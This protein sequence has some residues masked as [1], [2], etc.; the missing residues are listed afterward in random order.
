M[1]KLK[2]LLWERWGSSGFPA[3]WDGLRHGGGKGS[4]RYWEYLW[5]L[6]QLAGDE[7]SVLDVGA[8][9]TQ[10]L[11]RLF[12]EAFQRVEAVDPE[13]PHDGPLDHRMELGTWIAADPAALERF[14]CVTCVSVVEHLREP[15]DFLADLDRFRRAK[16]VLTLEFGHEPPAF[17]FQWTPRTLYQGLGRFRS[18]YLVRMEACP[19]WAD[20]SGNGRW[21]PFGMVLAPTNGRATR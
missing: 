8:G 7:R 15:A 11:P 18:H 6:D 19:I 9:L 4:Q 17:D 3:E 21:R 1:D 12:R 14:D 2:R 5:V 13:L 20:D 10:F 16:I